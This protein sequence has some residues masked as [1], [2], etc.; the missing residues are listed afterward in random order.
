MRHRHLVDQRWSAAAVD[1]A[2]ERGGL[3]D[4]R[5]LLDRV[6]RDPDSPL[7]HLVE[8]RLDVAEVQA[9][10]PLEEFEGGIDPAVHGLWRQYLRDARDPSRRRL[11]GPKG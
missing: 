5:G 10:R 2:L 4:R 9:R 1:S 7:A 3:A 11:R 8:A 6:W